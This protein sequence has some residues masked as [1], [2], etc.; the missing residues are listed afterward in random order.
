MEKGNFTNFEKSYNWK[1]TKIAAKI[2]FCSGDQEKKEIFWLKS[3]DCELLPIFGIVMEC[4]EYMCTV[5]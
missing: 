2:I 1:L 4:K 5:Y 3:F